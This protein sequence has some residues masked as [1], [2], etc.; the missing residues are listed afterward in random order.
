ML[1]SVLAVCRQMFVFIWNFSGV[2]HNHVSAF[3]IVNT[4]T[5]AGTPGVDILE[6]TL[7]VLE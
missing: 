5:V 3:F 2:L 1:K 4:H 7:N 6:G